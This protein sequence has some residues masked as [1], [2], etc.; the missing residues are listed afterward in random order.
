MRLDVDLGSLSP[1]DVQVELVLGHAKEEGLRDLVA[2]GLS[3][4]SSE[5]AAQNGSVRFEGTH[6]IEGSGRYAL[7]IRIRARHAEDPNGSLKDL[8]FWA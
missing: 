8:V 4:T 6:C 2:V 3:P 1:N 5:E 7:G